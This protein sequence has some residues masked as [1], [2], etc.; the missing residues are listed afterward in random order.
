M[1]IIE[2]EELSKLLDYLS[3]SPES[4]T[5]ELNIDQLIS[6]DGDVNFQD[7][8]EKINDKFNNLID[9]LK[10][11]S[12]DQEVSFAYSRIADSIYNNTSDNEKENENKFAE[13][14]TNIEYIIDKLKQRNYKA[15]KLIANL[16]KLGEFIRVDYL[17]FSAIGT[18]KNELKK[19]KY[20]LEKEIEKI[21]KELNGFEKKI[22]S[23]YKKVSDN[24]KKT[25][26]NYITILGIFAAIILTFVSG[27]VFSNSILQ[28]IDKA[29]IY[30]LLLI[31]TMIGFFITNI[32]LFLFNF[33]KSITRNNKNNSILDPHISYFN[34][35]AIIL[36]LV[37]FA[38]SVSHESIYK[39]YD[40]NS[41]IN[42][43]TANIGFSSNR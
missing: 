23:K 25:Q 5:G 6:V 14:Q 15:E 20:E 4:D 22:N 40:S 16:Y 38:V 21:K 32:L 24:I 13:I 7:E 26:T 27:L 1:K 11:F 34:L 31:S 35:A 42:V 36:I 30:K 8:E 9:E 17:R 19:S 2:P 37:L 43:N 39:K 12:L 41:T 33:V 10:Q 28:N 18:I 29:S 3:K